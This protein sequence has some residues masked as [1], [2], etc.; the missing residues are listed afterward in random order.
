MSD[1][2]VSIIR[3][4]LHLGYRGE[5]IFTMS[6]GTFNV[7][8]NLYVAENTTAKG[9]VNMSG[10]T[11]DIVGYITLGMRGE[12]N[13]YMTG[14]NLNTT[15][16]SQSDLAE[17]TVKSEAVIDGGCITAQFLRVGR[18]GAGTWIMNGGTLT[19]SEHLV[20][21]EDDSL[22]NGYFEFNGGVITLG[23]PGITDLI[24]NGNNGSSMNMT[25]SALMVIRGNAV[26]YVNDLITSE[27]LVAYNGDGI[28][29]IQYFSDRNREH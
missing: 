15:F 18:C 19:L 12:G 24:I 9:T 23:R 3:D 11:I 8:R 29:S 14:G 5:A 26:D 20:I 10:G 27:R 4:D 25:G 21:G 2:T 28:I 6:G 13:L 16:I 7:A 1:G 17:T 22:G